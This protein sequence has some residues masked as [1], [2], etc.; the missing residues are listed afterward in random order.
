MEVEKGDEVALQQ[1]HEEDE[2]NAVTKLVLDVCH[3][4]VYFVQVLVHKGKQALQ[5]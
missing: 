3:L 1:A 4:Q 5:I 2:V